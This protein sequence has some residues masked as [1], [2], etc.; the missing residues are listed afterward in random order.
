MDLLF[1]Y[2]NREPRWGRAA[3]G[4][5][6]RL[7]GALEAGLGGGLGAGQQGL[8]QSRSEPLEAECC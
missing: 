3:K 6:A 5:A 1:L 8:S 7:P 4:A 2:L